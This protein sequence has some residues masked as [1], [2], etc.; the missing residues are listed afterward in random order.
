MSEAGPGAAAR[1]ELQFLRRLLASTAATVDHGALLKAVIDETR[2]AT[3]TQVSSLYLWN[4]DSR[5]LVLTAT[6]GLSPSGIGAVRL[7]MGEGVTGWVA[8]TRT[9]LSVPDTRAEPRFRWV[10]GLD[11]ERYRSMLSVP[12]VAGDRL[13]GVINV[14]TVRRRRFTRD[15]TARLQAIGGYVAGIIERSALLDGLTAMHQQRTELLMMLAHDIGTPIAIARSYLHGVQKRVGEDLRAPV[16]HIDDE[17]TRVENQCRKA[18]ESLRLESATMALHIREFDAAN[19]IRSVARRLRAVSSTARVRCI[20][21]YRRVMAFGDVVAIEEAL[22][23]LGENALKYSGEGAPVTLRLLED[24][25]GITFTV[26]DRGPGFAP[27]VASAFAQAFRR[28]TSTSLPGTGL[29]LYVARRIAEGHGGRL[30]QESRSRGG[31]R[32]AMHIPRMQKSGG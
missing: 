15:E 17:L 4:E 6:N 25:D 29:G 2:E 28:S 20:L 27:E 9:P 23:N 13:I 31:S 19:L 1:S 10:P 18:L 7:G 8:E 5:E 11:Q 30:T 21:D 26:E 24:G 14:Q 12:I 22:L 16:G 3:L 32:V